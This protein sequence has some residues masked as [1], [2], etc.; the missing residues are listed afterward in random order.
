MCSSEFTGQE[1]VF[2][3]L[4]ACLSKRKRCRLSWRRRIRTCSW[5]WV[6]KLHAPSASPQEWTRYPII[7]ILGCSHNRSGLF[8]E[9][10]FFFCLWRNSNPRSSSPSFFYFSSSFFIRFSEDLR[11]FVRRFMYRATLIQ[12]ETHVSHCVDS[13]CPEV[14][15]CSYQKIIQQNTL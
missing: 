5:R 3:Y 14:S 4:L 2:I 9:N 1:F 11:T 7:C 15:G 12:K 13:G 10:N 6:V 8:E